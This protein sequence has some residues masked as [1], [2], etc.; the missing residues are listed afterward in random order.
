[1]TLFLLPTI[2][3]IKNERSDFKIFNAFANGYEDIFLML[4]EHQSCSL[5]CINEQTP[6][7]MLVIYIKE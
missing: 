5:Q 6:I 3:S 2:S 7:K 4:Q 1:M